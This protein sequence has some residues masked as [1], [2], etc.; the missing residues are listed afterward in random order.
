M[1]SVAAQIATTKSY[2]LTSAHL[3]VKGNLCGVDQ[4]L[5]FAL[6]PQVAQQTWG[7]IFGRGQRW[8]KCVL[9]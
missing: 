8:T 5:M 7:S 6:P 2:R 9:N 1:L 3:W 4:V